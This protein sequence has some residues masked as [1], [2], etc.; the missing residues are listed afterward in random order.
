MK[1]WDDAFDLAHRV[2]EQTFHEKSQR[3]LGLVWFQRG[4]WARAAQHLDKASLDAD[5]LASLLQ[6]FLALGKLQEAE[7][8]LDLVA[9]IEQPTPEL[10]RTVHQVRRLLAARTVLL[11]DAP[12]DQPRLDA[13]TEALGYL[14]CAEEAY[15]EGRPRVQVEGL[16]KGALPAG[17]EP[18][19]ALAF[20]ARFLLDQGKLSRAVEEAEQALKR[21]PKLPNAL[22][23]RGRVRQERAQPG[24]LADLEKAN[25]LSGKSDADILNA[26]A[27]ALARVGR[28]AE[29]VSSQRE[30][31]KLKPANRD[32]REQLDTL[33][34]RIG[35]SQSPKKTG[36]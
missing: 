1:R 16:L 12:T 19:P 8:R 5:V 21:D 9:R 13:V 30:A 17:L 10:T 14:V 6:A 7:H 27:E 4:D 28:I 3:I 34:K 20:R 33:E 22:Y 24:A 36:L 2:R 11:K 15:R 25:E 26:L 32:M 35:P 31:V 23:V 29:A 18:A